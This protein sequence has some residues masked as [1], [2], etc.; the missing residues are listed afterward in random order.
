MTTLVRTVAFVPDVRHRHL[1]STSQNCY[2][3]NQSCAQ[4]TLYKCIIYFY[5][6]S[7]FVES[8][9]FPRLYLLTP[10]VLQYTSVL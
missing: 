9:V 7:L 2:L 5:F 8:T 1:Y 6:K 10:G 4:V 3:S